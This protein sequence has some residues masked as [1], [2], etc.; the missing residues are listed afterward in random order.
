MLSL[1]VNVGIVPSIDA[2]L[3]LHCGTKGNVSEETPIVLVL[4]LVRNN[5]IVV[6]P[7][8]DEAVGLGLLG[9]GL[10]LEVGSLLLGPDLVLVGLLLER[11]DGFE[12]L[13]MLLLLLLLLL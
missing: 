2:G 1:V 3:D 12:L 13:L 6:V 5:R 7:I 9:N 10:G 11:A 8:D 4:A